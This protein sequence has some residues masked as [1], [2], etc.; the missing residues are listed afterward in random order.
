MGTK[1]IARDVKD[2]RAYLGL[3]GLRALRASCG[4]RRST[5]EGIGRE[6]RL[7]NDQSDGYTYPPGGFK[8]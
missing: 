4:G 5:T 1:A 7:D 8:R 3:R 2:E 6:C